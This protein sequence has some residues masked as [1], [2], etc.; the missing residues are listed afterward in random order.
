M[1]QCW[2]GWWI[3]DCR[4]QRKWLTPRPSVCKWVFLHSSVGKCKMVPAEERFSQLTSGPLF[5]G[6]G[7][8]GGGQGFGPVLPVWEPGV[9][10]GACGQWLMSLLLPDCRLTG[11]VWFLKSSQLDFAAKLETPC[12][13]DCVPCVRHVYP[14]NE[15]NRWDHPIVYLS[16]YTDC[17]SLD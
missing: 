1:V 2:E 9:G 3:D 16:G 14:S 17:S 5:P 15:T 6:P 8:G 4:L 13:R 10:A 12:T 7:S 11:E